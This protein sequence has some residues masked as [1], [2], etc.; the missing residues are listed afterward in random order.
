METP[1]VAL[2]D[3]TAAGHMV[4]RLLVTFY[5][6]ASATGLL[7]G[8]DLSILLT[9]F[10]D[11][12]LASTLTAIVVSLLSFLILAAIKRR[13]MALLL[14]V[15]FLWASYF[16]ILGPAAGDLSS[17][18][19]RDMIVV[20]ALLLI[21]ADSAHENQNDFIAL[22][23]ILRHPSKITSAMR[24]SEMRRDPQ[25]NLNTRRTSQTLFRNDF[26]TFGDR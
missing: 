16:A 4:V 5:T 15:I 9:P 6:V 8:T 11:A 10:M 2:P 24:A 20:G 7:S 1:T 19:W 13:A 22:R 26:D 12:S 17:N 18:H 21:Y 3:S 25:T 23:Y 14:A